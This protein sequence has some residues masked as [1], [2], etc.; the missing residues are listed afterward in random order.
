MLVFP[1]VQVDSSNGI[2]TVI[3]MTAMSAGAVTVHCFYEDTTSHCSNQA[4]LACTP[5]AQCPVGGTCNAGWSAQDFVTTFGAVTDLSNQPTGWRASVGS[6]AV[7]FPVVPPVHEDPFV[8]LLRCFV[9]DATGVAVGNNAL[10][11]E[12]TIERSVPGA[13]PDVARYNALGIPASTTGN[14]DTSLVLGDEYAACPATVILNHF[15]DGASDPVLSGGTLAT[16][17][18]IVPC[19]VNYATLQ[20]ATAAVTYVLFNEL[21][22]QFSEMSSGLA[23]QVTSLAGIGPSFTVGVAGTLTGQVR[24]SGSAGGILAVALEAHQQG[25]AVQS[26]GLN[27]HLQGTS[28]S[29]DAV[30][31]PPVP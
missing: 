8:G 29:P 31:V 26:T 4:T 3:Q 20:P 13:A 17:L 30:V 14:G 5:S 28:A 19:S 10:I 9:T 6:A 16:T 27:T 23:Q 11:G 1:Y 25:N 7:G 18:A 15:F 22:Q 21:E 2:D 12:A 24:L